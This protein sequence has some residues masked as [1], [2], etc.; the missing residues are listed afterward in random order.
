MIQQ[1][2]NQKFSNSLISS[3]VKLKLCVTEGAAFVRTGAVYMFTE[4]PL[5][6]KIGSCGGAINAGFTVDLSGCPLL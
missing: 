1:T 6:L 3:F 4:Q 2:C 5:K